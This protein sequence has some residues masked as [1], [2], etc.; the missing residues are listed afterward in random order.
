MPEGR[1]ANHE[2]ANATTRPTDPT[3]GASGEE[4][5]PERVVVYPRP[6]LRNRVVNLEHQIL[7]V[8]LQHPHSFRDADVLVLVSAM[9]T[10]PGHAAVL[11][12]ALSHWGEHTG[13]SSAAWIDTVQTEAGDAAMRLVSEL[14]VAQIRARHDPE[15]GRPDTRY[16][17]SLIAA[18]QE[19]TLRQRISEAAGALRRA[20]A[21]DPERARTISWE[22][23]DLQQQLES[24]KESL[25]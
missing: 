19:V 17:D 5:E 24:L 12:A 16:V 6:D 18:V 11:H 8:M 7:Q 13:L 23:R 10:D 25:L 21:V 3:A 2:R 1:A 20:E 22:L 9:F 4:G 15:T 14:S